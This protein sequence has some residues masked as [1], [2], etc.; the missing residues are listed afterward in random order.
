MGNHQSPQA[1]CLLSS[2]DTVFQTW[3]VLNKW[4][5]L[6]DGDATWEPLDDLRASY[7]DF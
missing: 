6:L 1:F 2:T 5:S 4:C 7:P 3:H